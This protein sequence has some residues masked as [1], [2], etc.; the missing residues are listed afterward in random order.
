MV[1][2]YNVYIL[3]IYIIVVCIVFSCICTYNIFNMYIIY[4]LI[5]SLLLYITIVYTACGTHDQILCLHKFNFEVTLFTHLIIIIQILNRQL[6]PIIWL[7]SNSISLSSLCGNVGLIL[8]GFMS[9]Y[10]TSTPR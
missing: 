9:G 5:G 10:W 1:L 7:V 6:L 3:K 8:Y 2:L 4:I